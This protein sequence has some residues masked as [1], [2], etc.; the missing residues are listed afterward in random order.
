MYIELCNAKCYGIAHIYLCTYWC[1]GLSRK[2]SFSVAKSRM[3]KIGVLALQGSFSEHIH[4][5][6]LLNEEVYEIRTLQDLTDDIQGL[7]IPGG[8]STTMA[9]FLAKNDFLER[10]QKWL[11]QGSRFMWGTCA[12]LILLA[13]VL[14]NEKVGGQVH[15]GG[16][17]ITAQRNSYGRQA[18]SCEQTVLLKN[19][20]LIQDG[21]QEFPGVFIRAPKIIE[22]K[23]N[24]HVLAVTQNQEVVGVWQD[25]LMATSFHP[26]LTQDC[27]FHQFFVNLIKDE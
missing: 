19:T 6:K 21:K 20:R 25:N 9:H 2:S 13:D 18:Q 22:I 12:G 1:S 27:R 8:E 15:L 17:S 4:A 26:E 11:K 10:L 3:V 16:L 7:V 24:V 23:P 5:F 14:E